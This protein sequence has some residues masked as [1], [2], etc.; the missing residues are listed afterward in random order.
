M[1]AI[2]LARLTEERQNWRKEHPNGFYARPARK[3]DNSF[4]LM[5]WEVGIPG[6]DGKVFGF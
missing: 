2:A 5:F 1:S 6:K 4:N 3:E